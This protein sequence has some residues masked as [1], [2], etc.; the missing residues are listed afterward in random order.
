MSRQS[1]ITRLMY[2]NCG[3]S[4]KTH[5]SDCTSWLGFKVIHS[6]KSWYEAQHHHRGIGRKTDAVEHLWVEDVEQ[7]SFIFMLLKTQPTTHVD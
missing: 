4:I 2:L 5:V 7:P 6:C 1:G 3:S